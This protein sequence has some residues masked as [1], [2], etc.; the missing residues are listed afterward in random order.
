MRALVIGALLL[1]AQGRLAAEDPVVQ[2]RAVRAYGAGDERLPPILLIPSRS[3]SVAPGTI[4]SSQITIEVDVQSTNVP[5]LAA[6]FVHCN[7]DWSEDF[8]T[9]LADASLQTTLFDW[10]FAST[11]SA[12][13][14]HRASLTLPNPQISF[15]ASGNW[16]AL[17]T[18]I[19]SDRI[20]AEVLF[21]VHEP[22]AQSVT[23]VVTDFYEPREKVSGIAFQMETSVHAPNGTLIDP[24]LK[25]CVMYR[26][27]R[28]YEPVVIE[29]F[30]GD[31]SINPP[32]VSTYTTGVL[33]SRV[34]FGLR[35]L[36]AENEYRVLD[37]TNL[38]LFPYTGQPVRLPLS[39]LPRNG[40]F[41]DRADD[42]A[43][44][45]RMISSSY[46][47]YVP[48]E[49]VL[50]PLGKVTEQDV[51]LVGSFNNWRPTRQWQLGYDEELRL[52]RLRQWVRR[53]RHNY[54]YATGSL[55]L[56][57]D[58]VMGLRY[59]RFEGNTASNT[60]TTYAFVYYRMQDFG[61]YDALVSV[62]A[63]TIYS[64]SR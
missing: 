2:I 40:F 29:R 23:M 59:E 20:L 4:G 33:S 26:N 19:G 48:I 27:Q 43:L 56:E 7:A 22:L 17:I 9:F 41:F 61:G 16:K 45:T 18:E 31:E 46:D 39:D 49:F 14:S 63:S 54:M 24:F 62:A 34:V 11:R 5:N 38:A 51:F 28:W 52:Y 53:G 37:L 6:R 55:D 25:T 8:N 15:R 1:F 32:S 12:W 60:N 3:G 58:R 21:F 47:E 42:G 30:G 10:T 50:D 44:V 35:G 57:R 36:P 13:H 64:S